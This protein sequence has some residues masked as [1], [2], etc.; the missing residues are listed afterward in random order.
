MDS[1]GPEF[2]LPGHKGYTPEMTSR[3]MGFSIGSEGLKGVSPNV[4][5]RAVFLK[6][7]LCPKIKCQIEVTIV[8]INIYLMCSC[9]SHSMRE[10][11]V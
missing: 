7:Y 2:N 9:Y 10:F 5:L 3:V 11:V 6:I 1:F 4:T 8:I